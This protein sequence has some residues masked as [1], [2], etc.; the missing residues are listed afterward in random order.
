MRVQL[1]LVLISGLAL[2]NGFAATGQITVTKCCRGSYTILNDQCKPSQDSPNSADS[3]VDPPVHSRGDN[4]P[5]ASRNDDFQLNYTLNRCQDGYVAQIVL[6]F[7]FYDD[8]SL[9]TSSGNS[10]EDFCLDRAAADP[11][12]RW[13]ARFCTLDPCRESGCIRKCCP[14]GMAIH[15]DTKDCQFHAEEFTPVIRDEDGRIIND[16]RPLIFDGGR[17][18]P[19]SNG[20]N[21]MF[22][23]RPDLYP[24]DEFY[25]LPSGEL[26]MATYAKD[27]RISK[28]CVDT[29]LDGNITVRLTKIFISSNLFII[30]YYYFVII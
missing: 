11:D 8:G 22:S 18:P 5:I 21:S 17:A 1:V 12:P 6:D 7:R 23:L 9:T 30:Y 25:I 29:F 2:F 16:S 3:Q 27:N 26:Y 19:C 10:I 28:H 20:S 13:L 24:G 4:R 14:Q 15:E